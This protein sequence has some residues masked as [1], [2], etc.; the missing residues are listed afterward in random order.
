VKHVTIG[1][2]EVMDISGAIMAPTLQKLL[3]MFALT[4]KTIAYVK[5]ERYNL[6]TCENVLNFIVS[7]NNLGL[8][9]PFDGFCFGHA[10]S[11]VC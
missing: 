4:N 10:F 8:L 2:F 11:K 7:C 3:D 1:L 9:K 6:Q 5:D